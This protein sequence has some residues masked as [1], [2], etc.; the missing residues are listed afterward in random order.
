MRPAGQRVVQTP[1]C[2]QDLSI[3]DV[4]IESKSQSSVDTSSFPPLALM[5]S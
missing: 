4:N 2:R 5:E 3:V 1:E